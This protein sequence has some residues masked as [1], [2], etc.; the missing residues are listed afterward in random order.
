M[1][2]G[3]PV[4]VKRFGALAELE[5]ESEAVLGYETDGQLDSILDRLS[6]DPTLRRELG[7]H[8]R[9]DYVRRWTPDVHIGSYFELIDRHASEQG[10]AELAVIAAS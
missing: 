5:T 8:G 10:A 9:R 3:V 1:A 7:G 4:V 6:A 2:V